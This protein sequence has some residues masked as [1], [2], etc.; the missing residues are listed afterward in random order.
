MPAFLGKA[1]NY[2]PKYRYEDPELT[3][4]GRKKAFHLG[5]ALREAIKEDLLKKNQTTDYIVGSSVL[6]RAQQTAY[7]MF[8]PKILWIIPYLSELYTSYLDLE[9]QPVEP[10]RQLRR[11]KQFACWDEEDNF[12]NKKTDSHIDDVFYKNKL[13]EKGNVG[14]TGKFMEWL[15]KTYRDYCEINDKQEGTPLV[16]VTHGKF[17]RELAVQLASKDDALLN[18]LFGGRSMVPRD[19][20]TAITNYVKNYSCIR[21]LINPSNNQ[22]VVTGLSFFDYAVTPVAGVDPYSYEKDINVKRECEIDTC[23]QPVCGRYSRNTCN[24]ARTKL[25]IRA[26][27]NAFKTKRKANANATRRA[28]ER[29]PSGSYDVPPEGLVTGRLNESNTE[30]NQNAANATRRMERQRRAAQAAQEKKEYLAQ[31]KAQTEAE[32]ERT[33]LQQR[34]TRYASRYVTNGNGSRPPVNGNGSRP[35]GNSNSN[36]VYVVED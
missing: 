10:I 32:A 1:G 5:A 4:W 30:N 27:I 22:A 23:R 11:L 16:F 17:M 2:G 34:V 31:L 7:L 26:N 15:G 13:A 33:A 36:T 24:N 12:I 8:F 20:K 6:L 28:A 21:L 9:N 35:R 25:G 14:N 19:W 3:A 18:Q 29:R